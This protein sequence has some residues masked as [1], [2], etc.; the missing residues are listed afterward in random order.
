MPP[1][2]LGWL[3]RPWVEDRV[4]EAKG[5]APTCCV[6][7]CTPPNIWYNPLSAWGGSAN[8][9]SLGGSPTEP[10]ARLPRAWRSSPS[11]SSREERGDMVDP[12]PDV[13]EI[14]EGSSLGSWEN[15]LERAT[16]HP[17]KGPTAGQRAFARDPSLPTFFRADA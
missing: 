6:P 16:S 3:E 2:T 14:V 12:R 7:P 5:Q 8:L 9:P 13:V 4:E 11:T 1:G 15:I 17:A 10:P